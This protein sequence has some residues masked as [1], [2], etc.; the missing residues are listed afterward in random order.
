M[1]HI[2]P[3]LLSFAVRVAIIY[4]LSAFG[5]TLVA[6]L[7]VENIPEVGSSGALYGLIGAMLSGLIRYWRMYT[8]KV[9]NVN[10]LIEQ[11]SNFPINVVF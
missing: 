10:I 7:F 1:L 5:G 6:A 11:L 9:F 4:V 3:F 2:L 8:N